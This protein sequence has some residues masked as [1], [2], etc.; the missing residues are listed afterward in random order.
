VT[1]ES[2][3][4]EDG[5]TQGEIIDITIINQSGESLLIEIP[6]GLVFTPEG[7]DEQNLM[8]L[9]AVVVTLQPE[10]TIVLS[11][12]VIC[13]E[14]DAAI[15]S[16]GSSYQLGYMESNDL[17]AFA[18]CVDEEE[19]V[20]LTQDDLGLQ[21]AVWDI[22]SGGNAMELPELT[23][24]EGGA[25]SEMMQELEVLYD[26]V[27]ELEEMDLGLSEDWLERCGISVGGEE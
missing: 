7:T 25:L 27:E 26:L 12:Y 8:V 20:T 13:I 1:I 11:P 5:D 22:A 21:F 15:P 10:E 3:E 6:A 2:I 14:A 18:Q 17:L 19:D 23:E 9:D 24:I 4:I 16:F